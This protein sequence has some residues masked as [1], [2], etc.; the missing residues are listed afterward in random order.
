MDLV[1][2]LRKAG[3]R[4]HDGVSPL[5]GFPFQLDS[6][7]GPPVVLDLPEP[8]LVPLFD[9]KQVGIAILDHTGRPR[10]KWGL[11]QEV[12]PL[13]DTPVKGI[14]DA[15]LT[16]SCGTTF[17]DGRRFFAAGYACGETTEVVLLVTDAQEEQAAR[18]ASREHLLTASALK[19]I[20]K[21]LSCKQSVQSLALPALHAVHSAFSL[22]S[23]LLWVQ[24]HDSAPMAL[25]AS[26]G[27]TRDL[28]VISTLDAVT[29]RGSL[30]ALVARNRQTYVLNE[31]AKSPLTKDVEQVVCI[32]EPGS[33]VV[34]PLVGAKSL[35]GV[36]ELVGRKGDRSLLKNLAMAETV[37]EH[38]SL[39][40]H[41]AVMFESI[42]RLAAFDPLTGIAN[43]R[44]LQDFL[45]ARVSEAQRKSESVGV[46]MIDVDHFRRFNEEEG[47]SAGDEALRHVAQ[48]LS[49]HMRPYD[50]AARYG[51][52]E[53]T[54]VLPDCDASTT[55]EVA[56]RVRKSVAESGFAAPS[57][58]RR[59]IAVSLGTACYPKD[60]RDPAGLLMAADLALYEA[61]RQGRNRVV[62]YTGLVNVPVKHAVP[63]QYFSHSQATLL[64]LD[65][66]IERIGRRL[67]LSSQDLSILRTV[68]AWFPVHKQEP[69]RHDPAEVMRWFKNS[70]PGSAEADSALAM[71]RALKLLWALIE[72]GETAVLADPGRFDPE[73][74]ILVRDF[75]DAA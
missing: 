24:P 10:V 69:E 9:P 21:A 29:G 61:K 7:N 66:V 59:P 56:E 19:R 74:V 6:S 45:A 52:E 33:V 14:V 26:T 12:G 38:I 13:D 25:V 73:L 4:V 65:P 54:L 63:S 55:S 1:A 35:I 22:G 50:I 36:L 34:L 3:V 71:R 75:G 47:H 28:D 51:G 5:T 58:A 23:A 20:G 53:F 41:S 62:A 16:G 2:A 49:E 11:A 60:A 27:T 37:A 67:R 31:A 46:V 57:G 30:A 48:I 43:H 40:I 18:E 17:Y 72:E 39:A 44:T 8:G 42:E 15:A 70:E 32:E 64:R 68:C